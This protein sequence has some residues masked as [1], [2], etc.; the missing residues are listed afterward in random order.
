VRCINKYITIFTVFPIIGG[1]Y[2]LLYQHARNTGIFLKNNMIVIRCFWVENVV[3]PCANS[4]KE[5]EG[6]LYANKKRPVNQRLQVFLYIS[7]R[8]C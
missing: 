3:A 8:L 7:F 2:L 6:D 4:E 1:S 5:G